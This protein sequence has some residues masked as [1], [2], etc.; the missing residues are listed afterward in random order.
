M[1]YLQ[2]IIRKQNIKYCIID[3]DIVNM[4]GMD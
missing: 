2:I 3:N 4:N 1:K